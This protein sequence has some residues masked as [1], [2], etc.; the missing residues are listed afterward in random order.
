MTDIITWAPCSHAQNGR[1]C[2]SCSN[3]VQSCCAHA[4][5]RWSWSGS[6]APCGP[7]LH[8]CNIPSCHCTALRRHHRPLGNPLRCV[9]SLR[10]CS[11]RGHQL[12]DQG[13]HEPGDQSHHTRS[14][15]D[16]LTQQLPSPSG[17]HAENAPA[18]HSGNM[19]VPVQQYSPLQCVRACCNCSSVHFPP[20][21]HEHSVQHCCT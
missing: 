12:P 7:S 16:Y 3:V 18:L 21:S 20:G 1:A 9:R 19:L 14:T 13:S 4:H 2:C 15:P 6:C 17:S 10:S 5:V 11:T 8:N